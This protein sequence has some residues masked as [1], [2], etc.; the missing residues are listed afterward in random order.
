MLVS[1]GIWVWGEDG[2]FFWNFDDLSYSLRAN[3]SSRSATR[4][5]RLVYS[6]FITNNRALFRLWWK[7]N[8]VKYHKV[9]KY[10]VHDCVYPS[11]TIY[12]AHKTQRQSYGIHDLIVQINWE[13]LFADCLSCGARFQIFGTKYL[14]DFKPWV[15]PWLQYVLIDLKEESFCEQ[16]LQLTSHLWNNSNIIWKRNYSG[17]MQQIYRRTHMPKCDFN[18]VAKQLYWN[19][20]LAWVFSSKFAHIPRTPFYKNTNEGLLLYPSQE[21]L[22]MLNCGHCKQLLALVLADY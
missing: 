22:Q 5:R 20:T 4:E 2:E 13:N 16:I 1:R 15:Q 19:H 7:E 12:V 11:P 8:L 17:N 9:S 21:V 14:K 6:I 18:K 3:V 10:Y